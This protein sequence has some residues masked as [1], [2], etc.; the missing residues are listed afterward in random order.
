[1]ALSL[2]KAYVHIAL[3]SLKIRLLLLLLKDPHFPPGPPPSAH[4]PGLFVSAL[5]LSNSKMNHVVYT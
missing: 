4:F 3:H 5:D 1:M 2:A